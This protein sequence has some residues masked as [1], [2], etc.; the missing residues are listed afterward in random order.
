MNVELRPL[1]AGEVLDRT[2][3]FFRA[4]LGMFVGIA[5][6]G[7]AVRTAGVTLQTFSL[8]YLNA[9][10]SA[11]AVASVLRG[12]SVLLNI[13]FSL[14]AYSLVFAAITAAIMALHLGRP[15]GI[16]D[17]YR[18][19]WPRWFRFVLLSI[20]IGFLAFWPLIIVTGLLAAVFLIPGISS[21][22]TVMLAWT[23]AF[24][25]LL[26]VALPICVWLLCRYALSCAACV[27]EDLKVWQSLK[28]SVSLSKGLRWRIFLLMLLVYVIEMI[29]VGSLMAPTFIF[30][31]RAHGQVSMGVLAYQLAM[32][33]VVT[34]LIS[35]IYGIGLTVIYLDARIRKE[36]YDIELMMQQAADASGLSA[37]PSAPLPV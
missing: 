28:R 34:A 26:V 17:A 35:P 5:T 37:D 2:F 4:R 13:G 24:G 30:L 22:A 23:A 19:I 11:H 15:T 31:A 1:S 12:S 29:L 27:V 3:Q 16:F 32:G 33:F 18:E 20:V 21:Q 6:V 25:L 9:H 14:L 36:G 10:G 7:A 8:R